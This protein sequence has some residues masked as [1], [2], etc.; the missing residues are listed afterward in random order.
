MDTVDER[1]DPGIGVVAGDSCGLFPNDRPYL[2]LVEPFCPE[3][4]ERSMLVQ[5]SVWL[6]QDSVLGVDVR[7]CINS[8]ASCSDQG[9]ENIAVSRFLN[10]QD[11]I[12][13]LTLVSYSLG[14]DPTGR[15]G[16]HGIK[17]PT[18]C[19]FEVVLGT[20]IIQKKK[21][22]VDGVQPVDFYCPMPV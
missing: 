13:F 7:A 20:F 15:K 22:P 18:D 2:L 4:A 10:L 12:D 1:A 17:A 9:I 8:R 19:S 16:R 14:V 6:E 11:I 5:A 21:V 3:V